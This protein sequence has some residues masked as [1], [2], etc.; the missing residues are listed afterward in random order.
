[1]SL[2]NAC[3]AVV[4]SGGSFM[5]PYGGGPTFYGGGGDF[6]Y[7]YGPDVQWRFMGAAATEASFTI[8][9]DGVVDG[10]S[11][12]MVVTDWVDGTQSVTTTQQPFP[13]GQSLALHASGEGMTTI[14]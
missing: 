10:Q 12:R 7:C 13:K 11:L 5:A 2:P 9:N 4:F 3:A 1:K 6:A 14:D 8:R